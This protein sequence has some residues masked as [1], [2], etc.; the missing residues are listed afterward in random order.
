MSVS[1]RLVILG[2]SLFLL[3]KG[4]E[5]QAEDGTNDG[6]STASDPKDDGNDGGTASEMIS[7]YYNFEWRD[8]PTP[9]SLSCELGNAVARA[10]SLPTDG[11][12][13][14][15][16]TLIDITKSIYDNVTSLKGKNITLVTKLNKKMRHDLRTLVANLK[17]ILHDYKEFSEDFNFIERIMKTSRHHIPANHGYADVDVYLTDVAALFHKDIL[18][19]KLYESINGLYNFG[20][21]LKTSLSTVYGS[22]MSQ[23][24]QT[25]MLKIHN[26]MAS[27]QMSV[28]GISSDV[29]ITQTIAERFLDKHGANFGCSGC[30][31]PT[32]R[33]CLK[34][35]CRPGFIGYACQLENT[36]FGTC[37]RTGSGRVRTFSGSVFNPDQSDTTALIIHNGGAFLSFSISD[38]VFI[39][40]VPVIVVSII[41]EVYFLMANGTVQVNGVQVDLPMTKIHETPIRGDVTVQQKNDALV[42]QSNIHQLRVE[43]ST[44]GAND[45]S[46]SLSMYWK[47]QIFGKCGNFN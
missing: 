22:I 20:K 17:R 6:N 34:G 14:T 4:V 11:P 8:H 46:V 3:A 18:W 32:D 44:D 16:P 27:L 7:D 24:A 33:Y 35:I 15:L 5:G 40:D 10:R 36:D 31:D 25:R 9:A 2:L 41:E 12:F 13:Q 19:W 30:L 39:D 1:L 38:V 45:V 26:K 23:K 43:L 29:L 42:L 37:S 21:T 28:I 47:T